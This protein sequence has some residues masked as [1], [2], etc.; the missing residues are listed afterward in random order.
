MCKSKALIAACFVLSWIQATRT[1]PTEVRA[2]RT[3][4]ALFA[5]AGCTTYSNAPWLP[6]RRSVL[7]VD[8]GQAVYGEV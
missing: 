2:T 4:Y 6:V 7:C 1:N 8:V 3:R 5:L